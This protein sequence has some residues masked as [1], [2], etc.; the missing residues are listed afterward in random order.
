MGRV[1]IVRHAIKLKSKI[2]SLVKN[3]EN[4]GKRYRKISN[5]KNAFKCKK[6]DEEFETV[7]ELKDHKLEKTSCQGTFKC[8]ECD[9]CYNVKER[10]EEH[11]KIHVKYPCDDCDKIFNYEATLEKH[12]QAAH[13]DLELYCHFFNNDKE[14]PYDD[15]CIFIHE[16]S[17][18]CRFGKT[19]ERKLCM[20]THEESD[21]D[22]SEES[23]DELDEC[24][25]NEVT[26][27]KLKP[28][29][30]KVRIA[31]EKVNMVL[32]KVSPNF[33]CQQ[34]DFEGRNH[35]GLNM[36]MKAKHTKQ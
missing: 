23:D 27:E 15:Q 31:L 8:E 22:T 3:Y 25:E 35:N 30:E 33:R 18:K 29:L 17:E 16:E 21:E 9:A 7:K 14:C 5:K 36:H 12:V 11:M 24:D 34:C 10:L 2:D 32:Q 13:E 20:Y 6:C 26:V 19:C 1:S 4:L 28:S